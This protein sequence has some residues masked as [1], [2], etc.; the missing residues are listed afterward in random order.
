MAELDFFQSIRKQIDDT[1]SFL[2]EYGF[3]DF[4]EKQLAYEYHYESSNTHSK[5]DIWFEFAPGSPFWVTVNG[6]HIETIEPDNPIIRNYHSTEDLS[7]SINDQYL[8]EIASILKRNTAVLYGD[9]TVVE[10]MH[11]KLVAENE[12]INR[13]R[14]VREKRYTCEFEC[15][16]GL[17]VSEFEANSL[18]EIRT[19]L[20]GMNDP[21]IT[22]IE[23]FDWNGKKIDF[24]FP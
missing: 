22:N 2:K 21:S 4:S 3:T 8:K 16:N 1:F 20:I 13:E 6:Y 7:D 14:K 9:I 15:L 24:S 23:V 18:T 10:N 12:E 11:Q 19:S 17:V 5:I